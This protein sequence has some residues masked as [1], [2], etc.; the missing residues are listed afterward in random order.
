MLARLW[1]RTEDQDTAPKPL[2]LSVVANRCAEP[3]P[4][5]VTESIVQKRR[6]KRVRVCRLYP[7]MPSPALIHA[8]ALIAFIQEQCPDYIGG[9]VPRPDLERFYRRDL[10]YREGWSPRHWTAIARQLGELTDRKS[11]RD[12]GQR[13]IGYCVPRP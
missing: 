13:F 4:R 12:G 8:R 5:T 10:C 2:P 3:L 7:Q 11:V 1:R 9:Y 6:Q